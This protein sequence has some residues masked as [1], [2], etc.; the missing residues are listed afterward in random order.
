MEKK[1]IKK[2]NLNRLKNVLSPKEMKN[3]K[4]GSGPCDSSCF[5]PCEGPGGHSGY[6]RMTDFETFIMCACW[7]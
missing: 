6:C 3:V 5:G 1:Q 2:I 4:G 7:V